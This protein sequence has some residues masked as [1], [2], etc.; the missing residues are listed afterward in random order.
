VRRRSSSIPGV[1]KLVGFIYFR[2]GGIANYITTVW[3][4]TRTDTLTRT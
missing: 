3:L 4:L 1:N 2:G